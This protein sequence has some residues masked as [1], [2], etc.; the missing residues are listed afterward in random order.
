LGLTA[1]CVADVFSQF[2]FLGLEGLLFGGL[3]W[4]MVAWILS[5]GLLDIQFSVSLQPSSDNASILH[6]A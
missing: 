4:H 5:L 2:W 3:S 6:V 1:S